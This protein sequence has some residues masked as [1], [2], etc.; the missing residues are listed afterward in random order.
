VCRA[1][2]RDRAKQS[3]R[4]KPWLSRLTSQS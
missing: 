1:C 2:H 3:R 4:D